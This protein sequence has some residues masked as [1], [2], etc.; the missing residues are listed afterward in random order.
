MSMNRS[1]ITNAL[2]ALTPRE[3]SDLLEFEHFKK[4][5]PD[6]LAMRFGVNHSTGNRRLHRLLRSG[7]ITVRRGY[8]L[9]AG[10]RE[11]DLYALTPD[12]ARMITRLRDRNANHLEA[13]DISNPIDNVHDLATLEVAIRSGCYSTARA[14]Q[15]RQFVC[16]GKTCSVIP[17]VELI[18]DD[19]RHRLFIEVE[20]TSRPDHITTKHQKYVDF[21]H[22]LTGPHPW[23]VI[24]FPDEPTQKL[25]LAEHQAAARAADD[26]DDLSL[27][28]G[29]L[30]ELRANHVTT[31]D[32][33]FSDRAAE[34]GQ[35][36]SDGL[37][38]CIY[39]LTPLY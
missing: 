6:L 23:L 27:C 8:P 18:S 10:G 11:R 37:L 5:T 26:D 1:Q 16:A 36:I 20:Q 33:Q 4:W 25:L 38:Q 31:L 15:E 29:C 3:T 28:Y 17:D 21:F 35:K 34:A 7:A 19:Q 39:S 13:P 9:P 2:L 30:A 24:L 22:T 12:G 32:G 14:F